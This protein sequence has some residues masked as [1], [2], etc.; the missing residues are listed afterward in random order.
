MFGSLC[1]SENQENQKI[2]R[3]ILSYEACE[4]VKTL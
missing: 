1:M 2:I 4:I 3:D